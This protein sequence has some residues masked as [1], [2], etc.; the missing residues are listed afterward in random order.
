MTA[1]LI[2]ACALFMP[3]NSC[4]AAVIQDTAQ[5]ITSSPSSTDHIYRQDGLVLRVPRAYTDLLLLQR[6]ENNP[7][8]LFSIAERGSVEAAQKESPVYE[9]AGWLFAIG[10]VSAEELHEM[11]CMDMTGTLCPG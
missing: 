3:W 1:A 9:G 11:L 2:T 6:G 8:Q 5:S 7:G 10:K 4:D